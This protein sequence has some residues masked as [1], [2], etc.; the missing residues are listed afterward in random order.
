MNFDKSNESYDCALLLLK[1]GTDPNVENYELYT[2]L[3]M[4]IKKG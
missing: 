3:E 4:A 2:P 1:Y